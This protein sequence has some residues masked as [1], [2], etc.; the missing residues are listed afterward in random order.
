[1]NSLPAACLSIL[2]QLK[3]TLTT[4]YPKDYCKPIDRLGGAT[5]GQHTRH[6]LEFFICLQK[7]LKS[8]I[9][10]YDNRS[11][12]QRIE[13]DQSVAM[14]II[15]QINDFIQ[16]TDECSLTLEVQYDETTVITLPSCLSREI[17]YNIEHAIHHMAILKIGMS[18]VADY[19]KLSP[20]FGIAAAT[21]RYQE[22]LKA[23]PT[24][25]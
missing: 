7:G 12:D 16:H 25:I 1:M 15:D 9:V 24:S 14:E 17:A 13:T 10:N 6:I 11:R 20:S 3:V 18:E 23:A 2:E 4:I 22:Q 19:V 5:I 21:M 8:G